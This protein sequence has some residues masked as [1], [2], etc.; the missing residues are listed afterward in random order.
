MFEKFPSLKD[1]KDAR[2]IWWIIRSRNGIISCKKKNKRNAREKWKLYHERETEES[3]RLKSVFVLFRYLD[4][5]PRYEDSKRSRALE[6]VQK[7]MNG[8]LSILLGNAYYVLPSI[9]YMFLP[10]IVSVAWT[11]IWDRSARRESR[12]SDKN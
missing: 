5:S 3:T 11:G 2:L 6:T 10:G 12:V 9:S 1:S 7:I 4:R 8:P